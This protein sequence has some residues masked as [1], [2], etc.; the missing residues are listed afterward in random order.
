MKK[1]EFKIKITNALTGETLTNVHHLDFPYETVESFSKTN[2]ENHKAFSEAM[3]DCYV[4]FE[5]KC[6]E[7]LEW[8]FIYGMPFNQM[9][10]EAAMEAG[11]MTWEQYAQKWYPGRKVAS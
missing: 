2:Q 8:S 10:D 7:S 9:A 4:T 5:W 1:A 3:P 6:E 11:E